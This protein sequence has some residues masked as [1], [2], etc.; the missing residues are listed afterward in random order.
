MKTAMKNY[1]ERLVATTVIGGAMFAFG[2]YVA[3]A[4]SAQT[5]PAQGYLRPVNAKEKF[6][7][8]QPENAKGETPKNEA[9]LKALL[10]KAE[11]PKPSAESKE[12][13]ARTRGGDVRKQCGV[14]DYKGVCKDMWQFDNF[15]FPSTNNTCGQAAAATIITHWYDKRGDDAFK[16]G[17]ASFLYNNYGPNNAFGMFGT[18][19]QQVVNSVAVGY[20]MNWRKVT[21][22]S[23][24]RAELNKGIPVIVIVDSERLRQKGYDYPRATVGIAA[25]YIVVYGYDSGFYYVSNHPGNWVRRNDFLE[26]WNTWIHGPIDGGNRGY[27]FWK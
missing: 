24:L 9:E 18:S 20:K 4:Q 14:G 12:P 25:H 16:K 6:D 8:P 11:A 1:L 22:E 2:E 10:G 21:G 17:V 15:D 7:I 3:K 19:W 13:A 27:V 26:S 23:D 5:A